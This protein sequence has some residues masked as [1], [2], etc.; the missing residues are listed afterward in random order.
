M[1]NDE[2]IACTFSDFSL[3]RDKDDNVVQNQ[4]FYLQKPEKLPLDASFTEF[5][6]MRMCLVWL[7]NTRP[8]RQFE[9]SK[10]AHVTV[11]RF[12]TDN[13]VL[14]RLL[15]KATKY[16]TCKQISLKIP[17]LYHDSLRVVGFADAS[18]ANNHD[19]STQLGHTSFLADG[20]GNSVPIQFKSYK[21]KRVV[22]SAMA[23]KVIA[24]S[25]LFDV[26]STLVAEMG[27]ICGRRIPV[28]LFTDS[29][30]LFDV[31]SKGSRTSEK[32]TML[33]IAADREGFRD[34]VIS[35]ISFVRSSQNIADGLKKSMSQ[36]SL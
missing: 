30:S 28:Q 19:L 29:K 8:D 12:L 2:T 27:D 21:S 33:D 32:R 9:I 11:E 31:I 4:H 10:L 25:D 13:A 16:A 3:V 22:P 24:F 18:F 23:G 35:D 15:N 14:A 5:R 1:G 20:S 17:K 6:S 26:A 34:K 36:T 7:A